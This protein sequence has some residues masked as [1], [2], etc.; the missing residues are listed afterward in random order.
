M[1]YMSDKTIKSLWLYFRTG[2]STYLNVMLNM[3]NFIIITY[4]LFLERISINLSLIQFV[5]LFSL[6]YIPLS[7][8]MGYYH[9][10]KQTKIENTALIE[11][12]PTSAWIYLMIAKMADNSI[13]S[14]ERREFINYMKSIIS[15]G[16][17]DTKSLN[18][19]PPYRIDVK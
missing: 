1:L 14:E 17:I 10:K 12:S 19:Q 8:I 15:K 6:T 9:Y 2:H 18:S 16:N 7:C 5:L 11:N 13:T 3:V 4:A